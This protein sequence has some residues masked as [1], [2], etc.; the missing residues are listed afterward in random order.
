MQLLVSRWPLRQGH[1]VRVLSAFIK[2]DPPLNSV[3]VQFA[4]EVWTFNLM[5]H[6][7]MSSVMHGRWR[8][9]T[10]DWTRLEWNTEDSCASCSSAQ[11]LKVTLTAKYHLQRESF[12]YDPRRMSTFHQHHSKIQ[13]RAWS[14][15]EGLG[16][17]ILPVLNFHI[18][19]PGKAPHLPCK[20][21]KKSQQIQRNDVT[22][23][24]AEE[25]RGKGPVQVQQSEG[26]L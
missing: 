23:K 5:P 10:I 6:Y 15:F 1:R 19:F 7:F 11:T 12:R 25:R 16:R 26:S 8:C 9:Q 20:R 2:I 21:P 14:H 22:D 4:A 13:E 18:L 3:S 24:E 17:V